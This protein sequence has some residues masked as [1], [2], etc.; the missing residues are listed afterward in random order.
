M[1]RID[2]FPFVLSWWGKKG[3][4][5]KRSSLLY[6]KTV[7]NMSDSRCPFLM[8]QSVTF[9][10]SKFTNVYN[11]QEH[12]ESI[13]QTGFLACPESLRYTYNKCL[14][15]DYFRLVRVGTAAEEP[16]GTCVI[17]HTHKQREVAPATMFFRQT[18]AVLFINQKLRTAASNIFL[19][20]TNSSIVSMRRM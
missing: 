1:S 3:K 12:H 16:P 18:H 15:W 9:L 14:Y 2:L 6:V 17:H 10:C 4:E 8:L 5:K 20:W 7:W 19:S 13:F 11:K